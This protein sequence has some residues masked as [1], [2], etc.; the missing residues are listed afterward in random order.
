MTEEI[1]LQDLGRRRNEDVHD[2]DNDKSTEFKEGVK[3]DDEERIINL[4]TVR[5]YVGLT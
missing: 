4:V 1:E 3:S 2:N 5:K